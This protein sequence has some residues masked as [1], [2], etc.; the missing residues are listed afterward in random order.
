EKQVALRNGQ[1]WLPR[2]EH[3]A[4]PESPPLEV[5]RNATYLITGG[6]GALGLAVA[7]HLAERGAG[8]IVLTSRSGANDATRDTVRALGNRGCRVAVI[9]A[10]VAMRQEVLHLFEQIDQI[11]DD[12]PLRGVIHAAG[13]L[14]GASIVQQTPK[15]FGDVLAPKVSGAW[16]LHRTLIERGVD[17]DL[18]V[19]FSSSASLLGL[20][21]H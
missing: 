15:S 8:Q 16:N 21:G 11:T 17:L 10:D 6:T 20:T 4:L 12:Q 5:K 9:S 18:F 14:T 1:R 7:R 13:A 2:L 19:L 3:Y